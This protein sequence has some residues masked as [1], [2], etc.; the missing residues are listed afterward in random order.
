MS[1]LTPHGVPHRSS[2]NLDVTVDHSRER[3]CYFALNEY[4]QSLLYNLDRIIDAF[5]AEL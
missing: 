4:G 5:I 1:R 3:R 2:S